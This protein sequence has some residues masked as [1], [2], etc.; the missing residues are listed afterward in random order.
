M[1]PLAY[2]GPQKASSY[3]Y[4]AEIKGNT[5]NRQQNKK[6]PIQ[7]ALDMAKVHEI[8]NIPSHET[9]PPRY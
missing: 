7:K 9:D 5:K 4:H 2:L 8:E 1:V 6:K 3:L